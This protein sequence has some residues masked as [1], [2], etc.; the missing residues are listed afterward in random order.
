M[1]WLLSS[2][3][4]DL[5]PSACHLHTPVP[6]HTPRCGSTSPSLRQGEHTQVQF[7]KRLHRTD[8]RRAPHTNPVQ[9]EVQFV[10]SV[11]CYHALGSASAPLEPPSCSC[12]RL[13]PELPGAVPR[14]VS[15]SN[16]TAAISSSHT[17]EVT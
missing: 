7:I 9:T 4:D 8:T 10:N 3:H 14:S 13:E 12:P 1:C 11:L 16:Q 2:N 15:R 6:R 17:S 5:H